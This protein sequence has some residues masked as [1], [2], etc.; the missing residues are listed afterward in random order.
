MKAK[1]KQHDGARP[2]EYVLQ[3]SNLYVDPG[4]GWAIQGAKLVK[5]SLIDVYAHHQRLSRPSFVK[6]AAKR[7]SSNRIR[8]LESAICCFQSPQN[9][10]HFY[11]NFLYNLLLADHIGLHNVPVIVSSSV[12]ACHF[13][14]YVVSSVEPF[15]SFQFVFQGADE[16][17]F[18]KSA[19]L[20]GSGWGCPENITKPAALIKQQVSIKVNIKQKYFITRRHASR[21][22][23]NLYQ[24]EGAMERIGY[25]VR[26][27]TNCSL[28]EQI[29]LFSD[30]E[31]I[32][33]LHG[34]ALANLSYASASCRFL[35]ELSPDFHVNPC[36]YWLSAH[37]GIPYS[38][39]VYSKNLVNIESLIRRVEIMEE[40]FI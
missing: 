21:A 13:F 8:M 37:I 2:S 16:L 38:S 3:T 28:L 26:D 1:I 18:V 17:I 19:I 34:A 11:N 4:S 6:Y 29:Q 7:L 23:L 27:C 15:R 32:V 39:T 36:F 10:W 33:A 25:S 9:Y 5:Q 20:T 40:E 22:P 31:A 12:A 30:A 14:K 24:L 35:L